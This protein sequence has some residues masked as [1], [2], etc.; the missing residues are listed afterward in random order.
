MDLRKAYNSVSHKALWIALQKLGVPE[1][2]IELVKFFHCSMK[3]RV[4]EDGT[5]LEEF[6]VFNSLR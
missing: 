3:A 5:S 6:D 4:R 2:M 1:T